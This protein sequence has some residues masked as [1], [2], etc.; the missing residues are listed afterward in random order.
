MGQYR[1]KVFI[2][3][4]TYRPTPIIRHVTPILASVERIMPPV[5]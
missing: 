1:F 4:Y 2:N 5:I 3:L